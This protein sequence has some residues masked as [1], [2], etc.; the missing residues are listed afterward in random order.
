MRDAVTE[1]QKSK[2]PE[3]LGFREGISSVHTSRTMMLGGK[4]K[5]A[6]DCQAAKLRLDSARLT[7]GR[8]HGSQAGTVAPDG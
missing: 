1:S 2:L 6:N 4:G 7:L 5:V 3:S 8:R